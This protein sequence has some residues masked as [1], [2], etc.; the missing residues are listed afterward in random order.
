MNK[1]S[2]SQ[3]NKY[4]QCP[5]SYKLHYVDR[6]RERSATAYL[7]F[8]TAMDESLNAILKD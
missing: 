8:G 4:N 1:L 2:F 5:R 3:I 7:A 6:L